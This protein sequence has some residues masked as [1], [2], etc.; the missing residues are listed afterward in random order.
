VDDPKAVKVAN[1]TA[2]DAP[3]ARGAAMAVAPKWPANE[4]V[5]GVRHLAGTTLAGLSVGC[6]RLRRAVRV[7]RRP[8]PGVVVDGQPRADV[9]HHPVASVANK[10]KDVKPFVNC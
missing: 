5:L 10:S 4:P 1:A 2:V 6:R 3:V 8:A 9:K 7:G